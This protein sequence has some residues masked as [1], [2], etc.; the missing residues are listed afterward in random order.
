MH[1]ILAPMNLGL[2]ALCV[3]HLP[4]TWRAPQVL[5]EHGLANK[6]KV[7]AMSQLAQQIYSSE[8]Q[9]GTR[10]RNEYAIRAFNLLLAEQVAKV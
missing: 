10:I 1:I 7:K 5:M 6:L 4:G 2:R 3:G 8:P 9:L